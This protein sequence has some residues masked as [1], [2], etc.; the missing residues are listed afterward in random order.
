MSTFIESILTMI[1]PEGAVKTKPLLQ[2]DLINNVNHGYSNR[3]FRFAFGK[4]TNVDNT[5]VDLW[6]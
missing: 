1:T 4:N 6:E 2:Q 3:G 5:L